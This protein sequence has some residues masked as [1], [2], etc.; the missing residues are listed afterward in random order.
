V[1]AVFYLA[2]EPSARRRWP[3]ILIGWNRFLAGSFWDPVVGREVIV[4][5]VAGTLS[6]C[7]SWLAYAE[8]AHWTANTPLP[9]RPALE[10]FRE[11]RHVVALVIFLHA[12]A[13]AAGLG[14]VFSLALINRLLRPRWVALAAWVVLY[15][16]L[17]PPGLMPGT[18]W[19]IFRWRSR[20]VSS[21]VSC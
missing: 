6:V 2:F 13:L 17:V 9:F 4:G 3:T 7:I 18:A 21:L 14:A 20:E 1:V 16:V 19:T 8:G 11:L 15:V 5:S 12:S 10:S